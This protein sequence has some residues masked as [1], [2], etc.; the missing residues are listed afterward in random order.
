MHKQ[1]DLKDLARISAPE[2]AFLSLYL[3]G[4]RSVDVLEKRIRHAE[5]LV[6][7]NRD[8]AEHLAEN[9]GLVG[10]YL[11]KKPLESGGMCIFACWALDFF[12][13]FP[14]SAPIPDVLW[15][16]SSPYIRPLAELQDGY[17]NFAVVV[18]DNKIAR[19]FLVA[20][21]KAESE[22][23]IKGNIKNHVRKGGW[24]QQRYERRRDGQLLHY[25]KEVAH[26]LVELDQRKD[27]RHV[28][29]VG[30]KETLAEIK[31]VLPRQ[32]A[33]KLAGEKAIDLG[34]GEPWIDKEIFD[35]FF[36]E[37][38]HS[39]KQHWDRI[40][41]EHLRG[42]LAAIGAEDVL[43]AARSG[44][45]EQIVVTRDAKIAG[46]RCRDCEHLDPGMPEKCPECGSTSLF[47]VDLVNEIVE[48]LA[49]TSAEADFVDPLPG[50]T[51]VGDI[52]A[53]LRY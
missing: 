41:T 36:E 37:E 24:S 26:K 46:Y 12:K 38:R 34:K 9:I 31:H 17:E 52:A 51:N 50:L 13:A 18:A 1:I 7:E 29:M 32:I 21:A 33:D 15:V 49:T 8:E 11:E 23:R 4:P 28:F 53:L 43:A 27:F 5:A 25:A 20:S 44:R 10:K 48:L 47:K 16:G 14:I 22:E 3:S 45:V 39:E 42:G 35:L 19:I 6:K 40:K 2:R 30:A